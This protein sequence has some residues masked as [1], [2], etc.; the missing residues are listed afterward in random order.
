M[1][2][3]GALSL[4]FLSITRLEKGVKWLERLVVRTNERN[5]W[6]Y[7]KILFTMFGSRPR[8]EGR[9][10]SILNPFL[11]DK[12][13]MREGADLARLCPVSCRLVLS[14]SIT[15]FDRILLT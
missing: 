12:M 14:T 5:G 8:E 11:L 10:M 9:M 4:F 2:H 13:E 15:A 3:D 6:G 7:A 1:R